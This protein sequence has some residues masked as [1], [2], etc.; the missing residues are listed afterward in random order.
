MNE[1]NNQY[2]E[3]LT[4]EIKRAKNEQEGYCN[5]LKT[6][7]KSKIVNMN[8]CELIRE[9]EVKI[10]TLTAAKEMYQVCNR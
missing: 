4:G 5:S 2:L 6:E 10:K 8:T 9:T 3:W 7:T 1:K